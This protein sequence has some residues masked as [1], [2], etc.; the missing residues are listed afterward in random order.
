MSMVVMLGL[1]VSRGALVS[2]LVV[3]RTPEW[4]SVGLWLMA[5]A[6]PRFLSLFEQHSQV[7]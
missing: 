4:L 1:D 6:S 3:T 2:A 7:L 5:R